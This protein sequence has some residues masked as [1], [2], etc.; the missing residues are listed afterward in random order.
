M[1]KHTIRGLLLI[2]AVALVLSGC[3]QK[4]TS[5]GT[6][7][8]ASEPPATGSQTTP[9]SNVDPTTA[10]K[11]MIRLTIKAYYGDE[12]AA[13]LV[14]KEVSINYKE[15]KDKYTAA[16]WTLKKAPPGSNLIPLADALG[17]KSAVLK[18]KQLTVDLTVSGEGRLGAP[19]EAML[20]EALQKTLFQFSEVDS[21]D[22]LVDGKPAESLM[23]HM[24]LLHPM[25]RGK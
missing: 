16:L 10:E 25:K 1:Q 11:D 12:Q 5:N 19:G 21:I 13:K 22:I 4:P 24:E 15:D 3:G 8:P 23:G 17:F 6:K 18:D 14:E 2:G 7:S 20:L 9:P